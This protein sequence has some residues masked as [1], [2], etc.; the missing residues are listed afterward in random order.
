MKIIFLDIDGVLNTIQTFIDINREYQITG[1]K[2]IE[3]DEFRVELLKKII[4]KTDAKIILSSS[5]KHYFQK[6]NHNIIPRSKRGKDLVKI[7]HKYE[8]EI[9]DMTPDLPNHLREDE[10]EEYLISHDNIENFVIIDDDTYPLTKF[11]GSNIIKTSF[12]DDG[13]MIKNMDQ[14]QGLCEEDIEKAITILN[15]QPHP[16]RKIKN[17]PKEYI[18]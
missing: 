17:I 11:I 9:Y 16:K 15:K 13:E 1:E 5:W 10:I 12:T 18:N 8:L 3:I 6:N 14:C 2:R 4:A 7:F